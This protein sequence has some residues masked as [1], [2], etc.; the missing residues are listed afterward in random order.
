M[1]NLEAATRIQENIIDGGVNEITIREGFQIGVKLNLTLPWA[2]AILDYSNRIKVD[3]VEVPNPRAPGMDTIVRALSVIP[4]R[5]PLAPH[6][7]NDE[8]D[9]TAALYN[10]QGNRNNDWIHILTVV[11]PK[12]LKDIGE[13]YDMSTYLDLLRQNICRIQQAGFRVGVSVEHTTDVIKNGQFEDVMRVFHLADD[14][15]VGIVGFADTRGIAFPWEIEQ[16]ISAIVLELHHASIK[17]HFHGDGGMSTINLITA[18]I[19]GAKWGDLS[20]I[21]AGERVGPTA[22]SQFFSALYILNPELIKRYNYSLITE[23]ERYVADIFGIEV[24]FNLPS[25]KFAGAHHAGIH[26]HAW[27]NGNGA[28]YEPYPSETFGNKRRFILGTAISGRTKPEDVEIYCRPQE[29][30]EVYRRQTELKQPNL[31]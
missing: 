27:K 5:P 26:T 17:G 23:Y 19:H 8:K 7:R 16:M 3:R 12:R 10:M 11:D 24:P 15:G 1:N 25:S 28:I 2:L 13:G 6:V 30:V 4:D 18:F 29:Q 9:V 21:G 14:L 31:P 20:A 22:L